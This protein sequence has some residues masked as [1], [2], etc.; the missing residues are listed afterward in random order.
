MGGDQPPAA[1]DEKK[2]KLKFAY[3]AGKLKIIVPPADI[4]ITM[5]LVIADG[6]AETNAS[7]AEGETITLL[8]VQV[9]K[10]FGH[11]DALKKISETAKTDMDAA[12][13]EF[14]KLD[15]MKVETKDVVTVTIK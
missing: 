11:K 15:G 2:K 12:K 8:D 13:A 5:K 9:G 1:E 6:I 3:A 10:L 7:Y 14:G 4:R